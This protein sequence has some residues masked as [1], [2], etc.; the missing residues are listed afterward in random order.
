MSAQKKI[1]LHG[2]KFEDAIKGI[3]ATPPPRQKSKR[4]GKGKSDDRGKK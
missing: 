4:R 2:L 3:L 1:S